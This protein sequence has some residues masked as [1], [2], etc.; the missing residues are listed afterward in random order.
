MIIKKCN[1]C[2]N[3]VE[4]YN[5]FEVNYRFG[6]ESKYDSDF[7]LLH[8]CGKCLDIWTAELIKTCI[9]SPIKEVLPK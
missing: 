8:L 1:R 2:G 7:F 9:H 6:Y 3:D 4:Y 5:E